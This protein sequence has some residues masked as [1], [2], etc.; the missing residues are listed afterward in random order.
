[1]L[2]IVNKNI[3]EG[4]TAEILRGGS[5]S[6]TLTR[7]SGKDGSAQQDFLLTASE[8]HGFAAP[9]SMRIRG[10]TFDLADCQS[11]PAGFSQLALKVIELSSA[12]PC[13]SSHADMRCFTQQL[14]A[15]D[16][17]AACRAVITANALLTRNKSILPKITRAGFSAVS[18]P[19]KSR[20]H[21]H[22]LHAASSASCESLF[23]YNAKF[24]SRIV[25][26]GSPLQ[27]AQGQLLN[28]AAL[29]AFEPSK[30]SIALATSME[31]LDAPAALL[32]AIETHSRA[33]DKP[34]GR[35]SLV[36]TE[37][38]R[39]KIPVWKIQLTSD[40]I[41]ALTAAGFAPRKHTTALFVA[42][43]TA[44]TPIVTDLVST[45]IAAD[46]TKSNAPIM[47]SE[48]TTRRW[49]AAAAATHPQLAPLLSECSRQAATNFKSHVTTPAQPAL[50]LWRVHSLNHRCRC[51]QNECRCK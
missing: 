18:L 35:V 23:R 20:Q 33:N 42:Y 50:D 44:D 9:A 39:I 5:V 22:T 51:R 46:S 3:K 8:Q 7:I 10:R 12:I 40:L 21:N 34:C 25:S 26:A 48:Q 37:A 2:A 28:I 27:T 29:H 38:S 17:I 1:M 16:N 11:D 24:I 15:Y 19:S 32:Q 43:N 31:V 13:L 41:E 30:P 49:L 6:I 36:T 45:R 14:P 4:H 47:Q